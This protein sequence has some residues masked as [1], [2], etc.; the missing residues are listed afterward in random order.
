MTRDRVTPNDL[1]ATNN[2]PILWHVL[3]SQAAV[4]NLQKNNYL[5]F[6]IYRDPRDKIVSNAHWIMNHPSF[7]KSEKTSIPQIITKLIPLTKAEYNQY[8]GWFK[9]PFF[10]SFK[11]EDLIGPRGGG[12]SIK[13]RSTI[14]NICKHLKINPDKKTVDNC[15][16]K[17]FGKAP[18]FR[19]GKIGSWKNHFTKEQ[20]LLA[21]QELGQLLIE[22]GYEK[23]LNW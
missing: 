10:Y 5:G 22:L 16:K 7:S 6:F 8:S 17:L 21:K 3:F 11:F 4:S 20:T 13:Q 12:T 9:V 2:S 15:V 23:D 18:T 14:I 19:E 1:P